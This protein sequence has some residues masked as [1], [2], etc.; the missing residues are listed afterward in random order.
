MGALEVGIVLPEELRLHLCPVTLGSHLPRMP[1]H[2]ECGWWGTSWCQGLL[3]AEGPS[4]CAPAAFYKPI[5][6]SG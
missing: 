1:L 5:S 4:T 2:L 6:G 3:Q